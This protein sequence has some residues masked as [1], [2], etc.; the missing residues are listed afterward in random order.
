MPDTIQEPSFREV[1][2]VSK[3]ILDDVRLTFNAQRVGPGK[4]RE[5][6][7][8]DYGLSYRM[9][10]MPELVPLV[11]AS[12]RN[13]GC[14]T[15]QNV[16]DAL[17]QYWLSGNTG[18]L[19][20]QKGMFV[21]DIPEL[22]PT[23]RRISMNQEDLEK[24]LGSKEEKRVVFSDDKS[25]R[26][27]TYGFKTESQSVLEL[28]KNPG[29]IALTGSEENAEKLARVSEYYKSNPYFS[30]VYNIN[31]SPIRIAILGS[32]GGLGGDRLTVGSYW[33]NSNLGY[34][35][36]IKESEGTEGVVAKK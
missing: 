10:A 32:G 25:V 21:Q 3:M 13:I 12:F 5:L 18:I 19:Y 6:R 15:A 36:G 11:Y 23:N 1:I 8:A 29:V 27:V 30:A 9:S 14:K 17:M 31:S 4:F 22:V 2:A 34:A 33:A 26:F 16:V 35:F 20:T 24:R 7:D 28:S